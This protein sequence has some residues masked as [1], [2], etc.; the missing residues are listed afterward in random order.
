MESV[1]WSHLALT[2]TD[3]FDVLVHT[4]FETSSKVVFH[5][6]E[7]LST[8][9]RFFKFSLRIVFLSFRF[10]NSKMSESRTKGHRI[11]I[12]NLEVTKNITTAIFIRIQQKYIHVLNPSEH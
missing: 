4:A 1:T 11:M 6:L 5:V 12:I 8:S 10:R 2:S 9:D 3:S 7:S